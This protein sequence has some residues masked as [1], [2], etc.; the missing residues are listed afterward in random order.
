MIFT[1]LTDDKAGIICFDADSICLMSVRYNISSKQL[2]S[3]KQA[4]SKR[5]SLIN[6]TIIDPI[7]ISTYQSTKSVMIIN[8]DIR[9]KS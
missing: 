6:Q 2:F 7:F 1:M 3:I 5:K 4:Y 8:V 9:N